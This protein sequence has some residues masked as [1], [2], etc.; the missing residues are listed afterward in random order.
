MKINLYRLSLL[1]LVL[2]LA[3]PAAFARK[4]QDKAVTL[5]DKKKNTQVEA[6]RIEREMKPADTLSV[7][8]YA[9]SFSFADSVLYLT[10]VQYIDKA[11]ISNGSYFRDREYYSNQFKEYL[12]Y[13]TGSLMQISA[14][15]FSEKEKKASKLYS[16][17]QQRC[18]KKHQYQIEHV[19]SDRF[20]FVPKDQ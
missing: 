13:S 5:G 10:D 6:R 3:A 4:R 7:Y 1:V 17:T 18:L 20:Q 12:E 2:A 15:F 14:V 16:K 11:P 9:A 8:A 19:G